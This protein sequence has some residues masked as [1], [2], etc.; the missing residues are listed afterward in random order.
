MR[1]E[2]SGFG[3]C[4]LYFIGG[5]TEENNGVFVGFKL[6]TNSCIC[7]TSS[8]QDSLILV[9]LSEGERRER[10]R[11]QTRG[12]GG[13]RERRG[14]MGGVCVCVCVCVWLPLF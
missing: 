11:G 5:H 1:G 2:C 7:S 3:Q 8:L 4:C 9:H 6:L 14:G 10:E 12:K 13:E